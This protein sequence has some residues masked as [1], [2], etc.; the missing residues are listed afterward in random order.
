LAREVE[1]TMESINTHHNARHTLGHNLEWHSDNLEEACAVSR[2]HAAI[3]TDNKQDRVDAPA[4]DKQRQQLLVEPPDLL[5]LL[6]EQLKHLLALHAQRIADAGK[7]D[8]ADN[9]PAVAPTGR[10][11]GHGGHKARANHHNVVR[12]ELHNGR[13][14][15]VNECR[16]IVEQTRCAED[17]VNVDN[18]GCVE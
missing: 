9:V 4:H 5:E 8:R 17:P 16:Q 14:R 3:V 7:E 12:H 2:D 13:G 18:V 6:A 1:E 15:R 10:L 11:A